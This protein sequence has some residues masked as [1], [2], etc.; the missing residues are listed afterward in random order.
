[1]MEE[2]SIFSVDE[3]M[4]MLSVSGGQLLYGF[5]G[6][7]KIVR[8]EILLAAHDLVRRGVLELAPDGGFH[9]ADSSVKQLLRPLIRPE[10]TVLLTPGA[11]DQPQACFVF[12]GGDAVGYEPMLVQADAVRLFPLRQG[13][14]LQTLK[15]RGILQEELVPEAH[16]RETPIDD[17]SGLTAEELMRR[18]PRTMALLEFYRGRDR[19]AE[20]K[21]LLTEGPGETQ[22]VVMTAAGCW[23]TNDLYAAAALPQ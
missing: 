20:K 3:L 11:E 12:S 4:V 9:L 18:W 15:D 13:D 19:S 14:W 23:S 17:C 22:A 6:E 21:V 7:K 10:L 16:R 5:W 1:M 2:Y 8:R